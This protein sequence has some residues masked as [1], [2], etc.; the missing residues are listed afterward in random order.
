MVPWYVRHLLCNRL[1]ADLTTGGGY[2]FPATPGHFE[3][4]WQLIQQA[5]ES[6]EELRV[7]MLEYGWNHDVRWIGLHKLTVAA[8]LA[9]HGMYPLQLKQAVA[10]LRH[11]LDAGVKP[12]QV[13]LTTANGPQRANNA[14]DHHWWR[15]RWR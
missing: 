5:K 2:N 3:F 4:F 13:R 10:A 9:P 12:S 11:L 1:W 15:L 8:E 6:G 14:I 7:M